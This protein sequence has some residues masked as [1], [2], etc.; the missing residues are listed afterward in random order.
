M[1]VKE[2]SLL[3]GK[4]ILL[5][6]ETF[7]DLSPCIVEENINKLFTSFNQADNSISKKYGGTGL[8]L[9]ICKNIIEKI[10]G[11]IWIEGEVG[12]GT[13]IFFTL[14]L[15]MVTAKL[16]ETKREE[17]SKNEDIFVLD[18]SHSMNILVVED[19]VVN[20]LLLKKM[21]SRFGQFK[22]DVAEN[23]V[24]AIECIKKKSYPLVFM[25]FQMPTLDGVSATKI[26]RAELNYQ[27]SIVGLSANAFKEDYE[28]AIKAGMDFYLSEP[29]NF[30]KLQ[31]LFKKLSE[32]KN[33]PQFIPSQSA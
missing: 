32:E 11:K 28:N 20:Q 7:F 33:F 16:K 31:G 30:D 8:G 17:V 13:N 27:G 25:D 3:Q 2:F 26:I 5:Y 24:Q 9:E 18:P 15:P 29:I 14:K 12:V 6:F 10:N 4:G 21:L 1:T 22:V 23:G 19:N